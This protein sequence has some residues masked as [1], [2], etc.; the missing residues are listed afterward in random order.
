M[1]N[2]PAT[3]LTPHELQCEQDEASV[4]AA[5]PDD[6]ACECGAPYG[7][8]H[9][10][11]CPEADPDDAMDAREDRLDAEYAAGADSWAEEDLS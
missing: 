3:A 11:G 10:D 7:C 4:I 6:T 8:A 2:A 1:S 5:T 9:D